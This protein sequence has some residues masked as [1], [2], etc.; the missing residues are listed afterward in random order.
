VELERSQ[1]K[2]PKPVKQKDPDPPKQVTVNPAVE[3]VQP[4]NTPIGRSAPLAGLTR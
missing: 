1:P 3:G 2:Q 4:K